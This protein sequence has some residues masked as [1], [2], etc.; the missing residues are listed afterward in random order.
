MMGTSHQLATSSLSRDV[1]PASSN[2]FQ[3]FIASTVVSLGIPKLDSLRAGGDGHI[4][5]DSN[6]LG[7][8]R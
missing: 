2:Q 7:E 1:D 5:G 8:P 3:V 6:S 4:V